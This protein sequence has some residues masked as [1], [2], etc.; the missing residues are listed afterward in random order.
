MSNSRPP[1]PRYSVTWD[2]QA[3]LNYMI[4][5]GSNET[6]LK[7]LSQKLGVLL[8]LTSVER[9]SEV[10]AHDLRFRRFLPEGVVFELPELVKKS[11]FQHGFKRSFHASFPENTNLCAVNC[12]WEYEKRTMEFLKDS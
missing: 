11:R 12:L 8:A 5:L 9:V 10:V 3:V 1:L 7:C 6:S 4:S 2:I